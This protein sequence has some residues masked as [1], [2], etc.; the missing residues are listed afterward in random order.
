MSYDALRTG[1]YS[2]P[3]Q[4][5]LVTTVTHARQTLFLDFSLA[6]CV[7]AELRHAHDTGGVISMAWVLM[8]DHLHWLIQLGACDT[9]AAVMKSVKGRTAHAI[10]RLDPQRQTIWQRGYHD[11]ALRTD[12]DVRGVAEYIANNPLRAGL[13]TQM[14]DYSH[15]DAAWV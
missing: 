13:V 6:R 4:V 10:K 2:S 11:H 7:V 5:Y 12:E 1:R 8:P 15:W 14:G 9:L 3:G